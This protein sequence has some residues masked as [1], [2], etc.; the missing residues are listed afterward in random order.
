MPSFTQEDKKII[1]PKIKAL[2]QKY[3]VK[4]TL[5][6][7]QHTTI[8]L[9]VRS[10][11]LDFINDYNKSLAEQNKH[12]EE[13]R[14]HNLVKNGYIDVC[15]NTIEEDF[16]GKC[17]AFLMLARQILFSVDYYNE[18]DPMTDYYNVAYYVDINIGRWDRP[19]EYTPE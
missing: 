10:G 15:K 3:G 14:Q 13:C 7:R 1:A 2:S 12:R 5:A 19:Y 4:C 9:N 17:K 18:S 16:T 8:V 6:I 11:Q